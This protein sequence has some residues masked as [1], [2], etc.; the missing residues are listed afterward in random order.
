MTTMRLQRALARAGVASRRAAEGLIRA[1]RVRVNGK[2]AELGSSVDPAR[3]TV[4]VD[5]RRVRAGPTVWIAL[6]K[7]LGYVVSRRDPE[8]R[9]TVFELVP[10][11]PGLTYVGRLDVMTTGLLLL[12]T[13]GDGANLLTHPRH[14]VERSY[15]VLV[16]GR[17][18]DQIRRALAAP[19]VIE[20]RPVALR[21]ARVRP[22]DGGRTDLHLVLQEGRYRIVRRL[23]EQLGLKVERLTRLSHGPVRLGRLPSGRWR[24]LSTTELAALRALRA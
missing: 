1:G 12:T 3:D 7:P 6:H 20:G 5:G 8:R 15:R 4:T 24:Y 16:H 13:D 21:E 9:P 19:V 17:T 10:A 2:V 11:V 22:G 23:C 18:P 14:Q